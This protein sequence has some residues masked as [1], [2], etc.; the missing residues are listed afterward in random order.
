M[1]Y[2]MVMFIVYIRYDLFIKICSGISTTQKSGLSLVGVQVSDAKAANQYIWANPNQNICDF[3][4]SRGK[5]PKYPDL[6]HEGA[7]KIVMAMGP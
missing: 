4:E 2:A 5:T 7:Q 3:P 1:H 6:N